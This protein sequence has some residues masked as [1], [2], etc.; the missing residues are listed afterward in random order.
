VVDEKVTANGKICATGQVIA[1]KMPEAMLAGK[2]PQ[3]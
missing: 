2:T 1:V 3:S